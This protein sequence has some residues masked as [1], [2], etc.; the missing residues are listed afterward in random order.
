MESQM[1]Q[2]LHNT[3]NYTA[4]RM[5]EK[6]RLYQFLVQMKQC[7]SSVQKSIPDEQTLT[8]IEVQLHFGVSTLYIWVFKHT[9][10]IHFYCQS[11]A[12]ILE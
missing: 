12:I 4:L 9:L 11:E 3:I 7:K 2:H 10:P 8:S 6:R 5:L 1:I